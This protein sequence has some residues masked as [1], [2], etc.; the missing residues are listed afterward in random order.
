MRGDHWG[1]A[2]K[3]NLLWRRLLHS[4]TQRKIRARMELSPYGLSQHLPWHSCIVQLAKAPH[5]K[6]R[7]S[8]T[9]QEACLSVTIC[10]KH[11][12][13]LSHSGSKCSWWSELPFQGIRSASQHMHNK[14][15]L[16]MNAKKKWAWQKQF[17][18]FH[19]QWWAVT[20]CKRICTA[21]H[22]QGDPV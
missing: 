12:R 4:Y 22:P 10:C 3:D 5:L 13:G 17:Q 1:K 6:P 18:N 20:R 19:P 21:R 15:K 8:H 11:F 2:M 9:N 16:T 7:G 14:L